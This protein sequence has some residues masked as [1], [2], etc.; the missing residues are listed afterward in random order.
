MPRIENN[1]KFKDY[2]NLLSIICCT[3]SGFNKVETSP[4]L[5][6]SFAAILRKILRIIFP[7]RVLGSPLVN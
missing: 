4:K 5:S 6:I 7:D 3:I 1:D 2:Y